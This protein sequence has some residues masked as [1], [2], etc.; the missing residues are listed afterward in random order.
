MRQIYP[1]IRVSALAFFVSCLTVGNAQAGT[2]TKVFGISLGEG[3]T[4][5]CPIGKRRV[6]GFNRIREDLYYLLPHGYND[7]RNEDITSRINKG[8]EV[9]QSVGYSCFVPINI[10]TDNPKARRTVPP[11]QLEKVSIYWPSDSQPVL[12]A[13]MRS[14][15]GGPRTNL[16]TLRGYALNGSLVGIHVVTDGLPVQEQIIEALTQKFGPP[17]V[18]KPVNLVSSGGKSISAKEGQWVTEEFH[19]GFSGVT[20]GQRSEGNEFGIGAFDIYTLPAYKAL[21]RQQEAEKGRINF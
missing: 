6:K 14:N 20:E 8:T 9:Y 3:G 18:L 1:L 17:T 4:Q 21:T 10:F 15:K 13:G 7:R 11:G 16:R 19:V 2:Q 12:P 5:V